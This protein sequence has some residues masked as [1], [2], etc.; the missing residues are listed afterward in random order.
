MKRV[1]IITI[2]LSI[3]VSTLTL[4]HALENSTV[5]TKDSTIRRSNQ[6]CSNCP[7]RLCSKCRYG[8]DPTLMVHWGFKDCIQVLVGFVLP[9]EALTSSSEIT[10]CSIQFPPFTYPPYRGDNVTITVAKSSDWEEDTVSAETAPEAEEGGPL[11]IIEVPPFTHLGPIDVTPVC[12]KA[13]GSADGQF[14]IYLG[15][16]NYLGYYELW[17]KDSGKPAILHVTYQ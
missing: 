5:T 11:V 13:K 2:A 17:S 12:Q 4:S 8:K 15:T 14:S 10:A 9:K 6:T 1:S 16:A 3:F 7:D